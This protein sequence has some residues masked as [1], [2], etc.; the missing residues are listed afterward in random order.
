MVKAKVY[1]YNGPIMDIE[2]FWDFLKKNDMDLYHNYKVIGDQDQEVKIRF[3]PRVFEIY[4]DAL[5]RGLFPAVMTPNVVQRLEADLNGGFYP[6]IFT[7]IPYE[8]VSRQTKEMGI[9]R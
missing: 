9:D 5:N 6:L 4:E 1:D 8:T 3:K 7:S 2:G